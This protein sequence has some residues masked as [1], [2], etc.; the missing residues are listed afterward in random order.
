VARTRRASGTPLYRWVTVLGVIVA[1]F[2]VSYVAMTAQAT[3][4]SYRIGQLKDRQNQLLSAQRQIRY[5][6]SAKS[7]AVQWDGDAARLGLSRSS[8]WSYL[9][10]SQSPV[11]LARPD[12][13]APAP[14]NTSFFD[15]LAIALGRPTEAQAKGR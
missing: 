1:V 7:S 14:T 3:Q 6:I 8:S 10:G 12:P 4:A 11:A 2:A 15:R 5:D 13:A 9:S